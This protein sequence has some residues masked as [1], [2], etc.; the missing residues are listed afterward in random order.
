MLWTNP[1]TSLAFVEAL[2]TQQDF[3][4]PGNFCRTCDCGS[5][6]RERT[7]CPR[8]RKPHEGGE[9]KKHRKAGAEGY[10]NRKG[11]WGGRDGTRTERAGSSL[12]AIFRLERVVLVVLVLDLEGV[13]R[14]EVGAE[15]DAVRLGRRAGRPCRPRFRFWSRR[16]VKVEIRVD[17][18]RLLGLDTRQE[19]VSAGD[20]RATGHESRRTG[21][22]LGA[23][24]FF[25]GAATGSSSESSSIAFAFA[26]AYPRSSRTRQR[27]ILP[28]ASFEGANASQELSSPWAS[29]APA[30]SPA[31]R[32]GRQ[33]PRLHH[34][35]L[36]SSAHTRACLKIRAGFHGTSDHVE[37]KERTLA[38]AFFGAALAFFGGGDGSSASLR[39]RS[40]LG[41]RFAGAFAF[42]AGLT[43]AGW[44]AAAAGLTL[45]SPGLV[46]S[47]A[48]NHV[49]KQDV[50]SVS[51]PSLALAFRSRRRWQGA[52]LQAWPSSP[53]LPSSSA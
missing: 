40:T 31:K 20:S 37:A 8:C 11:Y 41:L 23:A 7:A 34:R 5:P 18:D 4:D 16:V 22:A 9:A 35:S 29:A 27:P 17:P 51:S 1:Y 39:S 14:F 32:T 53:E 12:A 26:F 3:P 6:S 15:L 46:S 49:P 30:S 42:A 33:S 38:G 50:I 36:R 21:F 10:E 25:L 45:R 52:R 19:H 28:G 48:P 47:V 24:A 13:V 44:A 2:T 43:A